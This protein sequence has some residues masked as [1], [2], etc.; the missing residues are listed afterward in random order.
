M[1]F[2]VF[3]ASTKGRET[4]RQSNQEHMRRKTGRI[5]KLMKRQKDNGEDTRIEQRNSRER[6][7]TREDDTGAGEMTHAETAATAEETAA[8]AVASVLGALYRN[9]EVN[10]TE[11]M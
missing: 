11:P 3:I 5:Y 1:Q 10:I 6:S 2:K 4:E 7:I 9:S 8:I